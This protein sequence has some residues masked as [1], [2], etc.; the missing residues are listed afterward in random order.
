VTH[1]Q[2]IERFLDQTDSGVKI[3]RGGWTIEHTHAA[4]PDIGPGEWLPARL[5]PP[6]T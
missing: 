2:I 4:P 6:S 3:V 1:S 5:S